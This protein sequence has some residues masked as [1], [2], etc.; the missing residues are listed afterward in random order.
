MISSWGEGELACSTRVWDAVLFLGTF[1]NGRRG[2]VQ[3]PAGFWEICIVNFSTSGDSAGGFVVF[4]CVSPGVT[5]VL[6]VLVA[7]PIRSHTHIHERLHSTIK[8]RNSNCYN[9][10]STVQYSAYKQHV[11]ARHCSHPY[12]AATIAL[13]NRYDCSTRSTLGRYLVLVFLTR[14][15]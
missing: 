11:F 13:G 8:T 12:T 10:A 7:K 5:V 9:N 15:K 2:S 1:V 4:R 3:S 14:V 6:G